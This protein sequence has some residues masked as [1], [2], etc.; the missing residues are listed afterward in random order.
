MVYDELNHALYLCYF[1][2]AQRDAVGLMRLTNRIGTG[3]LGQAPH[4][5]TSHESIQ[6]F[7][8]EFIG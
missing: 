4:L 3:G 1:T 5:A 8:T 7:H 6:R 2:Y